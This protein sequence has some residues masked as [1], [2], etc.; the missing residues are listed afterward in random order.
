MYAKLFSRIAQ[1]SL[2]EEKVSTRYVFMM[3]L[4]LSDRH[5]DVIGTDIAIARMMNI[6]KDDF[7]ESIQPLLSPDLDSN[8]PDEEGRR[9]I[10]S[11]NGR[12][13]KL[14]NYQAY[15]DMKSD[16]EKR[17]YMKEYMRKRRANAEDKLLSVKLVKECKENVTDVKSVTHTEAEAEA[18][19][20]N[21]IPLTPKGELLRKSRS[22]KSK[23]QTVDYNTETM[24][25]IGSWF[26]RKETTLWTIEEKE[27]LD[28]IQNDCIGEDQLDG[29]EYF[30]TLD[31]Q[32]FNPTYR[33][34]T[35]KT[36]LNN[37]MGELEKARSYNEKH[38]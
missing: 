8:S 1:S 9:I 5:G 25:R 2:M 10:P 27:L 13:Y 4:A 21:N 15:R 37:W 24:K 3:L 14:V 22:K 11:E 6:S 28:M 23:N 12:G 18:E 36:L 26:G 35:L 19:A 20:D 29:M 7:I 32:P 16:D 38:Q 31:E 30:Y 34:T 33:R 17:E